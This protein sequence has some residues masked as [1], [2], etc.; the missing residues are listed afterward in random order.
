[1]G[2]NKI[3]N[4]RLFF[5]VIYFAIFI[6]SLILWKKVFFQKPIE[7]FSS[8]YRLLWCFSSA[9]LGFAILVF[10][11]L[12]NQKSPFPTY[13]SYYPFLLLVASSLVFSVLHIS[14]RTSNYVF[15]YFAFPLCFIFGFMVDYFWPII[16]KLI[17]KIKS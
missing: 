7:D 9:S 14:E 10:K 1:M 15:Y 3:N 6:L 5:S 17:D 11:N 8:L 16:I 2:N 12:N 13:I 4:G